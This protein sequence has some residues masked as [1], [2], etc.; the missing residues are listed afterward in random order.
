MGVSSLP[1][2]VARQRRGC[3]LNQSPSEPESSTLTTGLPSYPLS[4][5]MAMF[6]CGLLQGAWT[7]YLYQFTCFSSCAGGLNRRPFQV[8]LTLENSAGRVL[9][10][11][12]MEVSVFSLFLCGS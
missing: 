7:P 9:G 10:I 3:D 4:V 5:D 1:K 2:T 11:S 8:M 12:T 6:V